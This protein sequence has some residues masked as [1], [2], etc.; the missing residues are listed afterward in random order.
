MTFNIH[1][2]IVETD[3]F[4]QQSEEER[5]KILKSLFR[6]ARDVWDKKREEFSQKYYNGSVEYFLEEKFV[7]KNPFYPEYSVSVE[8]KLLSNEDTNNFIKRHKK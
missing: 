2:E 7:C 5:T 4:N 1:Y 6:T 3:L 8:A